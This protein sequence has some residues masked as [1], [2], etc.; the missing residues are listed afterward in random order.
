M[1][2]S[3]EVITSTILICNRIATILFDLGTIYLYVFVRFSL[4]LDM[5]CDMLETLVHVST[6]DEDLVVMD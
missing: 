2:A 3:N 5:M 6:P 1:E 4:R